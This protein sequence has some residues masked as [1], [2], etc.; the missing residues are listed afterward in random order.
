MRNRGLH[1]GLGA[2]VVLIAVGSL[3]YG[4][5]PKQPGPQR[6]AFRLPD[7]VVVEKDVEYG[8]AGQRSLKLDIVRPKKS[9]EKPLPVIAE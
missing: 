3:T 8:K 6:P 1:F 5:P 9:S 7:S 4:Q 2:V